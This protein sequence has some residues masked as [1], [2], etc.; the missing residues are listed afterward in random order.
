MARYRGPVCKLCRREGV[1]LFLKGSRCEGV[2]CA[3]EKR[4][5]GPGERPQS[6]SRRRV[7]DYGLQLREKQK[8]RRTYGVLERQF[9][10]YFAEAE[11][12]PGI[13]GETLL[14]ILERRLDNVVYRLGFAVSRAQAR[15]LIDQGHFVVRG[16]PTNIP[17]YL[18]QVGETIAVAESS[19]SITPI[20]AA[21]GRAGTR[22]LPVWLQIEADAM[23]GRVVAFPGRTDI[24]TQV[25]E[26]LVVEFYSR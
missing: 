25:Q 20:A 19:R 18:V 10:R 1:R 3:I 15:L 14:Q 16:R 17:S 6:R 21:V 9:R 13:T 8:L 24:D 23:S 11:R 2:K 26:G 12:R 22:R 5:A 4:E 7:S